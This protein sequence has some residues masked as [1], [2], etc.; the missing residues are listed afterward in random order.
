MSTPTSKGQ[1]LPEY[2]LTL[3]V[4]LLVAHAGVKAWQG[5]LARAESKQAWTFFLP[6]P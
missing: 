6:S 3:A 1:A 4:L 2:L 5:A